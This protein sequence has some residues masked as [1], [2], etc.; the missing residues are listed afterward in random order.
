MDERT[1]EDVEKMEREAQLEI[2]RNFPSY[3]EEFQ[4][5]LFSGTFTQQNRDKK[6]K[7]EVKIESVI[8]EFLDLDDPKRPEFKKSVI[9][10]RLKLMND[11]YKLNKD[12]KILEERDNDWMVDAKNYLR[13]ETTLSCIPSV[14]NVSEVKLNESYNFYHDSLP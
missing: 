3:F 9:K 8:S 7:K 5:T 6:E 10:L 14:M 1:K 12:D 4:K 2:E 11:F 13:E